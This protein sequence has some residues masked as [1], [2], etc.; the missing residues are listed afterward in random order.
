[1]PGEMK[2]YCVSCDTPLPKDRKGNF[3]WMC[4][5]EMRSYNAMLKKRQL[6]EKEPSCPKN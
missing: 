5:D 4:K 2:R 6:A 3:C 1:M